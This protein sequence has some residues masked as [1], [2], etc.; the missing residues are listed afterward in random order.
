MNILLERVKMA[1]WG[2]R[3]VTSYSKGMKQRIGIAQALI[4]DPELVI[5]D[6]PT[7]GLDPEGRS[8][9]REM[10]GE[11]R[12]EGRTVFINTHL[13]AELEQVAD[14]VA[15]LSKGE[16]VKEGGLQ[17]LMAVKRQYLLRTAGG[18]P[19]ELAD[20][21]RAENMVVGEDEI[22][23]DSSGPESVQPVIDAL[24]ARQ[25]VIRAVEEKKLSLE[26]LYFDAVRG[27]QEGGAQ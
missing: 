14:R 17:E 9:I 21:L 23:I 4:N 27:A 3:R 26:E 13:L 12:E 22:L 16:L 1:S 20:A 15:I 24:R 5:L 8:E 7:V 11:L 6:E 25:I 2:K 18:I 19:P 10:I